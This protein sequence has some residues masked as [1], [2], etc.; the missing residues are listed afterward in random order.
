[1]AI[2]NILN[3]SNIPSSAGGGWYA[4]AGKVQNIRRA[5]CLLWILL[6]PL[7]SR[8]SRI[9]EAI[10]KLNK[11]Y[12]KVIPNS[13]CS[14]AVPNGDFSLNKL[15]KWSQQLPQTIPKPFVSRQFICIC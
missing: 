8:Y 14:N 11:S 7:L 13:A 6:G 5:I 3:L 12:G 2:Y 10:P 15:P 4:G 1:M 9:I